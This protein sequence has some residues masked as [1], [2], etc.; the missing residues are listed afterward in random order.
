MSGSWCLRVSVS[1]FAVSVPLCRGVSVPLRVAS[2]LSPGTVLCEIPAL[3][4]VPGL[5]NKKGTIFKYAQFT[6]TLLVQESLLPGCYVE[7]CGRLQ[8]DA[9]NLKKILEKFAKLV[10]IMVLSC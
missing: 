1:P 6:L 10:K 2:S 9:H 8:Q 7:S 4:Y 3:D 5:E